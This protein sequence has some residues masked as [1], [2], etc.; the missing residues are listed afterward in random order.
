MVRYR[1]RLARSRSRRGKENE[2]EGK[3]GSTRK[4]SM[5]EGGSSRKEGRLETQI[6]EHV[7]SDLQELSTQAGGERKLSFDPCMRRF[8][9]IRKGS[10]K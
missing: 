9:P 5:R 3:E 1:N 4:S 6:G 10:L 8:L 2:G 7:Y